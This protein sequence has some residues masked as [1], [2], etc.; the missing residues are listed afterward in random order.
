MLYNV[1]KVKKD[2][3]PILLLPPSYDEWQKRILQRGRMSM[4]EQHR[5]LKTAMG[6]FEDGLSQPFY[7][8]VISDTIEHAASTINAIASGKP[9]PQQ[10]RGAEVLHELRS[11]LEHRL[12][13]P[14]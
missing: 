9:N 12:S 13:L 1:M 10:G 4:D 6:I 7:R 14:G 8:F 5:R 3:I 2:A 11:R